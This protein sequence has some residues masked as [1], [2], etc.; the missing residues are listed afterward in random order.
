MK[1]TKTLFLISL[2]N[3][4]FSQDV[5]FTAATSSTTCSGTL[6]EFDVEY[7]TSETSVTEFDFNDGNLPSGWTSS[8]YTVGQPCDP[9]QGDTP[10]NTNYF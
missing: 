1:F 3:F 5:Q 8:P 9:G 6:I 2:C 7:I 4:A 10:S